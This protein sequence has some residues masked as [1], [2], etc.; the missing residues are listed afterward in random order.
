MYKFKE[1]QIKQLRRSN[2]HESFIDRLIAVAKKI[3][4]KKIDKIAQ[5]R[6][7]EVAKF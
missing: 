6:N 1:Q 2:L 7:K 5:N 3:T 4:D